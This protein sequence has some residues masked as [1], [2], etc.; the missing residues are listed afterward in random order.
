[1]HSGVLIAVVTASAIPKDAPQTGKHAWKGR[2]MTETSFIPKTSAGLRLVADL[3]RDVLAVSGARFWGIAVLAG[4]LAV[5]QGGS[6][7]LLHPILT[8]LGLTGAP[9]KLPLLAEIGQVLG[10]SGALAIY[11][12]VA[13]VLAGLIYGH[14]L[15]VLR[16]VLD[17]GDSLRRRLYDAVMA[18]GWAAARGARPAAVAHSL[19]AEV[20]QAGWAVDQLLRAFATAMQVPVLL[21]VALTFSPL[22]TSLAVAVGFAGVAV[23][24]PLNRRAYALSTRLA[25]SNRALSAEVADELA[26]LRILKVLGAERL[27]AVAFFAQVEALR[28]AQLDQA[29]AFAAAGRIQALL[30]TGIAAGAVWVG[31]EAMGLAVADVLTLLLIFGRLAQMAMR[32]QDHWRQIVRVLPLYEAISRQIAAYGAEAEP[33][34]ATAPMLQDAIRL[35]GVG[36]RYGPSAPWAVQGVTAEIPARRITALT[37]P[38]GAGKSTLADVVMGLI[39]ATEGAFLIDGQPLS[40]GE[41][42]AWRRRVAYV[43]QDPFLFHDSI[44]ANLLMARP[45]AD[46]AALW[47]ALDRSA[48]G[49]V[50]NLPE[51]LET[52]VGERGARLSGGER[53]RIV[54]ARALLQAPDLLVLDEATSALDD[55]AEAQILEVLQALSGQMTVL[56]IAHRSASIALAEHRIHLGGSR[57]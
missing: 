28:R 35:A 40:A 48:A 6:L 8:L 21:A 38:S 42:V 15:A 24:L 33:Q 51:G 3:I 4:V 41:R 52:R 54:L 44:R 46:D 45:D 5:V 29:R 11:L 34:P 1:M 50:R 17:Y 7:L 53:Q 9:P 39:E 25:T 12:A 57:G 56:V 37:G 27:R 16:L 19:T 32:L 20:S 30:A 55:A 10:L 2:G 49:F 31:V 22:F 47:D 18:M 26:G 14:G 43:P 36:Y 23:L 13:V